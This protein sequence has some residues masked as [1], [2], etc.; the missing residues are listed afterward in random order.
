MVIGEPQRAFYGN[1]YGLTFPVFAHYGVGLWVA[2]VGGAVDPDSEAHDLVMSVFGGMSKGEWTR[3]QNPSPSGH[4]ITGDDG[5]PVPGRFDRRMATGWSTSVRIPIRPRPPSAS[6][7]TD[8]RWT[9]RPRP[10]SSGSSRSTSPAKASMPS[11]KDSRAMASPRH[12]RMIPAAT[13]TAKAWRG[14]RLRSRRSWATLATPIY[15]VW[16]RQRKDEVLIDVDDVALGHETRRRWN[17]QANWIRSAQPS[18][19]ANIDADT[20]AAARAIAAAPTRS[21]SRMPRATRRPYLL[22]G[23]LHCGLCQRKMQGDCRHQT[24]YYRCRYAAEYA[25]ANDIDHPRNVYL[26]E[27]DVVSGLDQWL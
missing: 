16:N 27:V 15:Q 21:K 4:G 22:R 9:R 20:F 6:A 3:I 13:H 7:C 26:R 11:P 23:V 25:T 19:P 12:P 1:Q 5:G 2:E 18:H 10:S 24:A 14:R 8:S 17:P